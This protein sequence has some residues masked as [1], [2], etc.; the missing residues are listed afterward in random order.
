MTAPRHLLGTL[1][2]LLTVVIIIPGDDQGVT[3]LPAVVEGAAPEYPLAESMIH[4]ATSLALRYVGIYVWSGR[5]QH[6]PQTASYT[7]Q[8]IRSNEHNILQ[9]SRPISGRCSPQ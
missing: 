3:I 2:V 5:S 9:Q 1:L 7:H 6:K 8:N 4:Q